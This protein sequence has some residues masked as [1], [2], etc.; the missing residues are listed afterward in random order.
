[1]SN[2]GTMSIGFLPRLEVPEGETEVLQ[3]QIVQNRRLLAR[4]KP[5]GK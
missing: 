5:P 2:E 4:G 3:E 1:M